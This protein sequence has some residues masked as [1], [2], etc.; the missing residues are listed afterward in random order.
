MAKVALVTGAGGQ[1]GRL[2]CR[3]LA[4]EGWQAHGLIRRGGSPPEAGVR[5]H[6]AAIADPGALDRLLRDLRPDEIYHLGAPSFVALPP[7]EA[8][9]AYRTMVDGTANLLEAVGRA[10]PR[11]RLLLAGSSEMFGAVD[12]AP[13]TER[14]PFRPRSLYGAAK[15]AGAALASAYRRDRGLFVCTA[16]LYNHESPLRP[17]RFVTRRVTRGAARIKLGLAE[18]LALGDLDARRDWGWAPDY[19]EAMRLMLRA[20]APEDYVVATGESRSVRELCAAA[21][22]RLG[23]DWTAH[24]RADPDLTRAPEVAPLVGDS[25]LIRRRLGWRPTRS[26]SQI[27]AAMVDADMAALASEGGGT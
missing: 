4:A 20:E 25:G 16:I 15:A 22:G 12:E 7:D 9:S 14:T 19:V 26:F 3:A 1:D 21:F 8:H 24:V 23:L 6:E 27:V 10:A 17:E 11:A 2:L 13:Q 5:R 18:G